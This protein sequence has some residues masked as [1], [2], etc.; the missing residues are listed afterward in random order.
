MLAGIPQKL[1]FHYFYGLVLGHKHKPIRA[2]IKW[3]N[4]LQKREAE[5][6]QENGRKSALAWMVNEHGMCCCW[7]P[8]KLAG[9]RCD[10]LIR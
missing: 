1:F 8:R 9:I 5:E 4:C 6:K 10:H 7:L 3:F 2:G